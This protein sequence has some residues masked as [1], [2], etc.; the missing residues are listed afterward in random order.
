VIFKLLFKLF[1]LSD[2]ELLTKQYIYEI[3]IKYKVDCTTNKQTVINH[4]MSQSLKQI[5]H[6]IGGQN[7][8]VNEE[9]EELY[10]GHDG[11]AEP[12]TENS[13]WVR[14]VL[15]QLKHTRAIEDYT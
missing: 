12:Q 9:L 4:L 11:K 13:A 14:D 15:Q 1:L 5:A 10:E 8:N 2:S 3:Y 6:F 7:C